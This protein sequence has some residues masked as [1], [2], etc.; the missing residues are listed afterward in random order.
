MN[1]NLYI[2]ALL[3]V[4]V[5]VFGAKSSFAQYVTKDTYME[6]TG[7]SNEGV[8]AGYVDWGG[9][10]FLWNPEESTNTQINGAAPGNGVGGQAHF[11]D[12]GNF[13][14]GSSYMDLPINTD[15]QRSTYTDYPYIYMGI[16]FPDNQSN[17]GF[18]AGESV[19]Y[20]G[21]GV[22]I[23]TTDAGNTWQAMWTD[24][25]QHGIEA[26]S[27]PNLYTGY[28]GGWNGYFAKTFDGGYTWEEQNPAGDDDV[29]FYTAIKFKDY[30]NGIVAAQLS[31]GMAIYVTADGGATWS[32]ATGLEGIPSEIEYVSGDTYFITT[33]GG[34]VQ[35]STDNGLSWST[36]F[37]TSGG[38]FLT[39]INF[40]DE[41]TGY[42]MGESEGAGVYKTT[43]G[44][45]S[46]TAVDVFGTTGGY[47]IWRDIDWVSA[48]HLFITGTPDMIYESQDAGNTWTWSNETLFD[49][50]PALY[51]I[52]VTDNSL[53]ISGSQGTFY[54]KS[55]I[56]S[57]TV[58][59]MS[60]YDV[61]AGEWTA[62]GNLGMIVDNTTSAGYDISGD[63][64][65]VVGNSYINGAST[66]GF[67]WNEDEGIIDLGS[68][69]AG[70]SARANA[71]SADGSVIVGWQDFNGP[72][73]SAVWYKNPDGG[74]FANQYLLVDPEGDANDEF[75]Q[76][77]EARAVSADGNWIGG[78]GDYAFPNAWIWSEETG[79][80]DIGNMGL[81][82]GTIGYVSAINEDG[83]IVVGWYQSGGGPW[84]PPVYT[85]FIWTPED[86]AQSLNTYVTEVLGYDLNGDQI[87]VPT[88]LSSNGKYICGW[89]FNP[90]PDPWG[91]YHTFRLQI[92]E[93]MGVKDVSAAEIA[94]YPNPAHDILNIKSDTLIRRVSIYGSNGSLLLNSELHK[95]AATIDVSG[96][97]SGV[98]FVQVKTDSG[99]QT[100][101]VVKR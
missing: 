14:S 58:A 90:S 83:S 81:E 96:Y 88:D 78:S 92:S 77:G 39:G 26:M 12:D 79:L 80:V 73:K 22:I 74:Y 28:V 62:L 84:D 8:V 63:G 47:A 75:N 66:N 69:H 40:Y 59:E 65:T 31:E 50:N 6:S 38:S 67:A 91:E 98:Y 41:N 17:I 32:V 1:F 10:Y 21:N 89:S 34:Q 42:V 24:T 30:D 85:P 15:W 82:E 99:L 94:L 35:K 16:E 101:K 44:G 9:P 19:T 95:Y 60:R 55:L 3:A 57:Q 87:F 51:S 45:N 37:S 18:A 48:D 20:N 33:Y 5:I 23:K 27:F 93:T 71:V 25:E 70:R 72:W 64:K 29:Y 76:L 68:I 100:F 7:V 4:W 46:W 61:A 43:D 56:S 13:L 54:K 52:A 49:G 11:S 36:V 86:G 97:N 53:H 2:K